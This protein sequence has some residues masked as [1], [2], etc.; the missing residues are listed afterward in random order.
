MKRRRVNPY[1]RVHVVA[2]GKD[3]GRT[4]KANDMKR[5]L[6]LVLLIVSLVELDWERDRIYLFF[7]VASLALVLWSER[8]RHYNAAKAVAAGALTAAEGASPQPGMEYSQSCRDQTDEL[9]A[10]EPGAAGAPEEVAV[11]N[12][13]ELACGK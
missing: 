4:I 13:G 3:A 11:H 10:V 2:N 12:N 1:K 9:Q 8:M 7:S 6:L 5:V